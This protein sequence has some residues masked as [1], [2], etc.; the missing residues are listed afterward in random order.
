MQNK[1]VER[2]RFRLDG[3]YFGCSLILLGTEIFIAAKMH[4]RILRPYA[5]DYLVVILLYC[6]VRAFT[7]VPVTTAALSVLIFSYAVEVSQYFHLAD[8]LGFK[9]RSLARVLLG[10]YFTWVDMLMYTLGILTVLGF[11]KIIRRNE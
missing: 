10:S 9:E 1:V 7:S 3:A 2:A 6:L 5:G 8:R 11:E 4:D